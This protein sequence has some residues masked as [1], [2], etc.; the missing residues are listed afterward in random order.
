MEGEKMEV[1]RGLWRKEVVEVGAV[2][3]N[4]E[5]WFGEHTQRKERKTRVCH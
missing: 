5:L 4:G 3:T 1:I 2:I